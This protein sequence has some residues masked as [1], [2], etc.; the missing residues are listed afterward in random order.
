MAPDTL[1]KTLEDG[2]TPP[3]ATLENALAAKAPTTA[4]LEPKQHSK[5]AASKSRHS[6][7]TTAKAAPAKPTPV[8][9]TED[10]DVDLLAA[11]ITHNTPKPAA[12]AKPQTKAAKK[13]EK[14]KQQPE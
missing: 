8:A 1:T 2:V 5:P 9:T 4:Q 7:A 10:Q 3:A 12:P 13:L 6:T 11:L 14:E